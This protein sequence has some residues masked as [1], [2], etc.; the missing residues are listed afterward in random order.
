MKNIL[1]C[2]LNYHIKCKIPIDILQISNNKYTSFKCTL[3]QL[4]NITN[5]SCSNYGK[6]KLKYIVR[7]AILKRAILLLDCYKVRSTKYIA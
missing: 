1:Y 3:S 2:L 4:V 5:I 6:P 7:I